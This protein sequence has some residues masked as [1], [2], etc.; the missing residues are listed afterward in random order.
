MQPSENLFKT[1]V[2][3]VPGGIV[4][5][6]P[7]GTILLV[8]QQIETMFGYTRDELIGAP[9]E[10]LLPERFR[11][12]HVGMRA[13]Y[14]ADPKTRPMGI[15]RDLAARRKDG[16]EFPVE[17]GLSYAETPAG[18]VTL[19]FVTDITE[20]KQAEA[21]VLSALAGE[22][23]A[24]SQTAALQQ[25]IAFLLEISSLLAESFD[26]RTRL[27]QFAQLVVSQIADWC[28]IHL[29]EGDGTVNQVA[30][31]R[32]DSEAAIDT[33]QTSDLIHAV[34]QT[35]QTEFYPTLPDNNQN[36]GCSSLIIVPLITNERV[37]GALTLAITTSKH[38]FTQDDLDLAHE[39]ARRAAL[40]IENARLYQQAQRLNAELEQ[41]V[42]ER[43]AQ[44]EVANRELEAFSY[45]ISHDLRAPLR[46]IDGFSRI[47]LRD[48]GAQLDN[49]G[50]RRLE[51]VRSNAQQMGQLIDDLLAF[52]RLT[53]QSIEK[54][55][56]SPTALV[57]RALDELSS[58]HESRQVEF[59]I[60]DLPVCQADP[61]LLKQVFVNLLTNALKFTR[62]CETA[63]INVGTCTIEGQTTYF[64]KDNGV[65]FDMRYI[66]KLFGV[67]QRLHAMED[68]EGTGVGLAIV[69]RII[70]RH[71]GR[72]WAE[73]AVGEG[74]AFYF[75]LQGEA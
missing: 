4:A 66:D 46:A 57:Y 48:Y 47:L 52:S 22:Q 72:I 24:H 61:A 64:V 75:T 71:G 60:E 13:G 44:L 10:T 8:N 43:T 31:A 62:Q 14:F 25:R 16:S 1:L 20:R 34:L 68:Y 7:D 19:A 55:A 28:V 18:P 63:H 67:F 2:E 42:L 74:A 41:R 65:G 53:R 51:L 26:Y 35:G 58:E 73:G 39:I 9:L 70:H 40:R 29:V 54:Q 49:D 12:R 5:I 36:L 59:T 17:I 11:H 33:L 15:G 6:K 50:Q 27:E 23:I 3:A 56:V 45:S 69:Q 21:A 37:V 32:R 38:Q 30:V